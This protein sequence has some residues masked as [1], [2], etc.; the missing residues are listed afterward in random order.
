LH[1]FEVCFPQFLDFSRLLDFGA[2]CI[3]QE[4]TFWIAMT[5]VASRPVQ[6]ARPRRESR[7]A[8]REAALDITPQCTKN[9]CGIETPRFRCLFAI[10]VVVL[11]ASVVYAGLTLA[12]KQ[13]QREMIVQARAGGPHRTTG[14]VWTGVKDILTDNPDLC[15]S[16]DLFEAVVLLGGG[17]ANK[18]GTLPEWVKRRCDITTQLYHC[19]REARDTE[20]RRKG[21][22]IITTSAGTAHTPNA[23]DSEGFHV[24][25]ARA[26]SQYL[27]A[28][29]VRAA[30]IVEETAG[31]YVWPLH[32]RFLA[33]SAPLHT[34]SALSGHS[35]IYAFGPTAHV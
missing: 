35:L 14:R 31:T 8:A 32:H 17:P 11:F 16:C 9:G 3:Y 20:P 4:F 21:L 28:H 26:S 5:A 25:E 23:I 34:S 7:Q 29:G 19:C 33:F 15:G 22:K 18:D 13:H 24:S 12:A 27:F 30:D 6:E 2:D 1:F 10:C